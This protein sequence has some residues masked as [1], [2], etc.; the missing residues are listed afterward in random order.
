MFLE[1]SSAQ[2]SVRIVSICTTAHGFLKA[3]VLIIHFHAS[4]NH[5]HLH[6]SASAFDLPCMPVWFRADGNK[7]KGLCLFLAFGFR[8]MILGCMTSCSLTSLLGGWQ[9]FFTLARS[10]VRAAL[11]DQSLCPGSAASLSNRPFVERHT[12]TEARTVGTC[13]FDL[14]TLD[15]RTSKHPTRPLMTSALGIMD[16][17]HDSLFSPVNMPASPMRFSAGCRLPF[18]KRSGKCKMLVTTYNNGSNANS[19]FPNFHHQAWTQLD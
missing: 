17:L 12:E 14:P 4:S 11:A 9:P 16:A 13:G 1:P 5:L 18:Y 10:C 3:C 19:I 8:L 15:H 2:Y 7:H 6:A